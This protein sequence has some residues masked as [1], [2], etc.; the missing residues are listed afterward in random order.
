MTPPDP[1]LRDRLDLRADCSRCVGLCCVVPAFRR[2]SEF[3]IDKPA[4]VAC[5]NLQAD[6]RCAIH[7]T[8][9]PRGFAGCTA[10]DCFGAGQKVTQQTFTGAHW[11]TAPA[12]AAA[13]F[14]VFPVVQALQELL[15][16]LVEAV[17]RLPDEPLRAELQ[18]ELE[19]T[20][21]L[22]RSP[23]PQLTAVDLDTHRRAVGVLLGR[24]SAQ[25]R[26]GVTTVDR[27]SADHRAADHRGADHRGADLAGADLRHADLRGAQLRG[28]LLLGA[29]LRR[30]DLRLAD[31]LGSD[32]RGADLRGADLTD[33]LF[34]TSPQV[35]AAYGDAATRLPPTVRRPEHWTAADPDDLDAA[36][37]A[38]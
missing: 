30:A 6:S 33:S 32:L 15:H 29:D 34:L 21:A 28:A 17:E 11:R 26:A 23:A 31:L 14:A 35:R 7:S 25:L 22:T 18:G 4:E 5:P 2:S 24:T 12:T 8:L 9:R 13:M 38:P 1:R 20:E 19:R 37:T 36:I 27:R 16:H 10:Y 3:A